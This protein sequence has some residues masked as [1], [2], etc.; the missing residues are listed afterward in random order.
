MGG[1]GSKTGGPGGVAGVE[2]NLWAP[3]GLGFGAPTL[4]SFLSGFKKWGSDLDLLCAT[5]FVRRICAVVADQEDVLPHQLGEW[6]SQNPSPPCWQHGLGVGNMARVQATGLVQMQL[7]T[8][9]GYR[10]KE[11]KCI[12]QMPKS[13]YLDVRRTITWTASN[14]CHR[15]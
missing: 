11:S 2:K 3:E 8:L 14:G 12:V 5:F 7:R 10:P 1:R 15:T 13:L 4:N 9:S 6:R